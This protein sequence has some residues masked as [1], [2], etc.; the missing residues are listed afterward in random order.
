MISVVEAYVDIVSASLFRESAP[1]THDLV[2]RLVENAELRASATWHERKE[3][4]ETYHRIRLSEF[5]HWSELDAGIEAR[6]AI[7]HGLGQLTTRQRS[8]KIVS[9]LSQIGVAVHDGSVVITDTSLR[10]CRD[11]CIE[12]VRHLDTELPQGSRLN[13]VD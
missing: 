13:L 8:G 10:R 7:A 9:K 6:N 4:F 5:V 11:V 1:T 3:A 2:R 12:F